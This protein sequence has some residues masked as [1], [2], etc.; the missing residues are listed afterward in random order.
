MKVYLQS[1]ESEPKAF[2]YS[3]SRFQPEGCG[4]RELDFFKPYTEGGSAIKG[5]SPEEFLKLYCMCLVRNYGK[6]YEWVKSS[7]Y[8]DEDCTLLC[9][10]NKKRQK[11]DTLFCHTILI[12]YLLEYMSVTYKWDIEVFYLD[13]RDTPVWSR[14]EFYTILMETIK[15]I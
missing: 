6:I 5:V 11:R 15:K 2:A 10:C 13:G 8:F 1:F 14:E 3:V 12:G 9:W 7:S 4:F